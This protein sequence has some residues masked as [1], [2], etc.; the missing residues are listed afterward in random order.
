[1]RR[2]DLS[3]DMGANLRKNNSRMV[4]VGANELVIDNLFNIS[5]VKENPT[6]SNNKIESENQA[7]VAQ[8]NVGYGKFIYLNATA[9]NDW[10]STLPRENWS[11]FYPSAGVSLLLND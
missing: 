5:N 10:S 4:S 3:T 8:I 1:M 6:R 7:V 2:W 9:G 11:Y